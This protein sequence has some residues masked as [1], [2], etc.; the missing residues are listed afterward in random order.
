MALS[1]AW[2]LGML[3]LYDP[4]RFPGIWSI[5]LARASR[6]EPWSAAISAVWAP[7]SGIGCTE[8]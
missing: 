2:R 3:L 7:I 4:E 6:V 5:I 1:L 8:I